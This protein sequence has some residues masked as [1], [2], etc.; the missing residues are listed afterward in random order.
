MENTKYK[1]S[2]AR[3]WLKAYD[4]GLLDYYLVTADKR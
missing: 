2:W 3:N 1:D 4:Q